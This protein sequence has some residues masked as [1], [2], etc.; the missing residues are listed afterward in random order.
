MMVRW[1]LRPA[2][3]DL[4]VLG[5]EAYPQELFV[6]DVVEEN[7]VATIVSRC[8]VLSPEVYARMPTAMYDTNVFCCCLMIDGRREFVP[9][10]FAKLGPLYSSPPCRAPRI[11]MPLIPLSGALPFGGAARRGPY[12]HSAK[13]EESFVCCFFLFFW[14]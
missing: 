10:D 12:H 9:I 2:D 14:V 4:S 7:D 3:V 11:N 6:T 8:F 13:V 1:M 5:R